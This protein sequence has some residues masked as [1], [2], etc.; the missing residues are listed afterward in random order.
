M[1]LVLNH[2]QSWDHSLDHGLLASGNPVT[3]EF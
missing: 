3:R 1:K 2:G